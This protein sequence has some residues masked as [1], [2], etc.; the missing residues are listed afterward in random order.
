MREKKDYRQLKAFAKLLVM[1][2]IGV[3]VAE[4]GSCARA[5]AAVITGE[6]HL[7]GGSYW[8]EQYVKATGHSPYTED[9]ELLA[10]VM[11]HENFCN[12]QEAMELTG[13]VVINRVKH[14]E[15]PDSIKSVLYERGQ[16][17]T[18]GKFF[19]RELPKV[20]YDIALDLIIGGSKAP[21]NCIY[22]AQFFQGSAIYKLIKG[23]YFCYE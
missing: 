16:Y 21:D 9:I 1:I 17:S 22:Q 15:Y 18:T 11:Y 3:L 19:T 20:C 14:P 8:I 23:E 5:H 2:M 4:V 7:A 13:S 10:E 12:G 6:K